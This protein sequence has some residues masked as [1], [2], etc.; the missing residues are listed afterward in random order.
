MTS[1]RHR[2]LHTLLLGFILTGAFLG[3]LRMRSWFL[4]HEAERSKR[5]EENS[6]AQSD[7]F[8]GDPLTQPDQLPPSDIDIAASTIPESAE[9]IEIG[10][11]ISGVQQPVER[12]KTEDQLRYE[13]NV[14]RDFGQLLD[15]ALRDADAP[16]NQQ[17]KAE[18]V[19]MLLNR[20]HDEASTGS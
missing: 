9:P 2:H 20:N 17:A 1:S 7:P 18:M 11:I 15:P 3:V 8:S 10:R 19:R 4:E 5:F 6:S 12:T 14:Q 16:G 13:R